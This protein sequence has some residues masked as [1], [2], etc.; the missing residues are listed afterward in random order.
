MLVEGGEL[1]GIMC[2]ASTDAK[3]TNKDFVFQAV[4][5]PLRVF[6]QVDAMTQAG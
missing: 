6:E 5:E 1:A 4:G 3:L 2:Q